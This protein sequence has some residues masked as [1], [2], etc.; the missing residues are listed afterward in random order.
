MRVHVQVSSRRS[1]RR[2]KQEQIEIEFTVRGTQKR[3]GVTGVLL[4]LF[5]A[6]VR[7]LLSLSFVFLICLLMQR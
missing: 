7:L 3:L 5:A 4:F 1:T 2:A 6:V